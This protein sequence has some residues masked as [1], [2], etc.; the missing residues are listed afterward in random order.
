MGI[1]TSTRVQHASPAAAYAHTVSRTWYSDASLPK[2]AAR[3]GCRDIAYQLVHNTDIN[4]SGRGQV[5]AKGVAG[6]TV[7]SGA[8][9]CAPSQAVARARAQR[10]GEGDLLP[11][12]SLRSCRVPAHGHARHLSRV[13]C[14]KGPGSLCPVGR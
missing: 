1:V 10:W 9:P 8:G 12:S 14:L 2:E 4:V 11:P 13:G 6:G 5:A 7:D 3:Q